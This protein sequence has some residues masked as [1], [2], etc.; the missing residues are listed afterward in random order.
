MRQIEDIRHPIFRS[1][2]KICQFHFYHDDTETR[3]TALYRKTYV[4]E[5]I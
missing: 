3:E 1:F 4:N 2:K 5:V